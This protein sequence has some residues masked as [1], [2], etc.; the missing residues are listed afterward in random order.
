MRIY[1]IAAILALT[2]LPLKLRAAAPTPSADALYQE[3]V[4]KE[5]TT[6]DLASAITLYK[7][8]LE[9]PHVSR[10]LQSNAY[11][12]LGICYRTL[13]QNDQAKDVW[14]KLVQD[15]TDQPPAYQEAKIHLGELAAEEGRA[16]QVQPSTP[17]VV[18]AIPK[19]R[20]ELQL[21]GVGYSA[22]DGLVFTY[23]S[24]AYFYRTNRA[25]ELGAGQESQ[26]AYTNAT[27]SDGSALQESITIRRTFIAATHQW[28][29][30]IGNQIRPYFKIGP[31][32]YDFHASYDFSGLA[33]TDGQTV[34]KWSPGLV[35]ETGITIGWSRGFVFTIGYG[36]SAFYQPS[37]LNIIGS[38][39]RGVPAARLALGYRW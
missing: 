36:L 33:P 10:D 6:R 37:L 17:T 28:E 29:K 26:T 32:I 14:N 27:F 7:E 38:S 18:Y 2:F 22:V 34:N 20:L 35:A 5:T 24:L 4:F 9:Q 30:P 8:A 1:R 31:A 15:F 21:P 13:G 39:I 12:R 25:V 16:V 23:P 19:T 3:A 11:L